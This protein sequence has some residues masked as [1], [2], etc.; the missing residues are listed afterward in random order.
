MLLKRGTGSG[1]RGAGNNYGD[2]ENEKMGT[3]PDLNPTSPISNFIS[4]SQF[5][6]HFSFSRSLLYVRKYSF[7]N[8]SKSKGFVSFQFILN[9]I[10]S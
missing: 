2:R 7:L 1:E 10:Y 8:H 4:N 9:L 5:C 3:K 6:S